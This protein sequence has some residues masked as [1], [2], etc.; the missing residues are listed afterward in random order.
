VDRSLRVLEMATSAGF[1]LRAQVL[2]VHL[3]VAEMAPDLVMHQVETPGF[4]GITGDQVDRA[5]LVLCFSFYRCTST[6][7]SFCCS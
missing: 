2:P 5:G 4:K 1:P 7:A 3:S 6:L